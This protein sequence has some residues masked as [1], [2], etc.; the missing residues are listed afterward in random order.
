MKLL[1]RKTVSA[2]EDEEITRLM[3][4]IANRPRLKVEVA[5]PSEDAVEIYVSNGLRILERVLRD[6]GAGEDEVRRALRIGKDI[7]TRS[8][9]NQPDI[10]ELAK[11]LLAKV[12]TPQRRHRS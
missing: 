2:D 9:P 4:R 3:R 7:L 5:K 1:R 11:Q 10:N 12:R 8:Y 6:L